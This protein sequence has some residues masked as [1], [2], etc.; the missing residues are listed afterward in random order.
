[1]TGATLRTICATASCAMAVGAV[2]QDGTAPPGAGWDFRCKDFPIAAWNPPAATDA[3]YQ[4]YR[5][6]GFNLVMSPRYAPAEAALD[7]AR[8]H[9]LWLMLDTYTPNDRPWGGT[10]GPYTPH[11][12]HHPAT[13]PELRWLQA[14]Y[15][16]HP[17]LAGY[18]LGD[19]YGALPA[20]LVETTR[21][22][23]ENGPHLFP[24]VCQNVMSADSL[25]AA[26]N[27]IQ[28]PQIYPTLYEAAWPVEEQCYRYCTQLRTL[29]DGCRRYD[30][31]PWPMFNVCGV[32]SDSLLRFQVYAALAYGAQGLWYFT[33][34][35]GLRKGTGGDSPEEVRQALLP[36]WTDAAA[37]NRRVAAYGPLLLGRHCAAVVHSSP[38]LARGGRPRATGLITGLSDGLLAGVLTKAGER[39]LVLLVDTRTSKLRDATPARQAEIHFHAAV[40]AIDVISEA[41]VTTLSGPVTR[42]T[43]RGG[44]G[45]LLALQ[46]S[47]LDE[48]CANLEQAATPEARAAVRADGL[49]LHVPFDEGT[50]DV[51]RDR[52][53]RGQDIPLMG[54][55]WVAGR[56]GKV[57]RLGGHGS[58]GRR[59]EA[60]LQT[61][62]AITLAAW[63]RP[64]YP[65]T[66]YGP[67]V[68]IGSGHVERF[69]FGFGPDDLYPVISDR[70]SHSGGQLYVGG[71]KGLIPEGTWGHVAICAG[72]TGAVTYVNGKPL[73]RSPFR[74]RFDFGAT[75]VLIGVRGTEEY[76]GD[77]SDLRL[78]NRCL[79]AAEIAALA[80]AP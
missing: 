63:V 10:A 60:D 59:L 78:W 64:R 11:P 66:G 79:S 18:L 20:E 65:L 31:T 19:D 43:L 58:F 68:Y 71:M 80:A 8:K 29:R 9:G 25:A 57:A 44:E 56:A 30:L 48:L 46:G 6:A 21:F 69:E 24:W 49:V 22:L 54:V 14:R 38:G 23:R 17:A 72:P 15:G 1:M 70:A 50:G 47:G 67:V 7:L 41:G 55:Q 77:L 2:G 62:D 12:T 33:Y 28:D 75:D 51:A 35:D 37:A 61:N 5:E 73:A 74:G 45:M 39:P 34:A 4:V 42:L 53:G 36:V 3:E 13:L 26:G 40:T 16:Q 52:S 76:D 27:P 32:E